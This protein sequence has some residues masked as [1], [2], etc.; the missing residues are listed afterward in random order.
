M[1]YFSGQ[2]ADNL[3]AKT[4]G[5]EAQHLQHMP[6]HSYLRIGRYHDAVVSNMVAHASD[7]H[8]EEHGAVAYAVAHDL[9]VLL[10]AAALSGEKSVAMEYS[11]IL[12]E[13]YRNHPTRRDGPGTEIGW[14]V[15]RTIRLGFGE[16][17][18]VLE[19]SDW[20]PGGDSNTAI[21]HKNA[22]DSLEYRDN[23]AL[24]P[25][26]V[27]LGHY[28]KGVASLWNIDP[29]SST[30]NRLSKANYY[31]EKLG[32]ASRFVDSDL[33]GMV[34]VA[35]WSLDASIQFYQIKSNTT[36]D[37]NDLY[38]YKKDSLEPVLELFQLART[39]QD[40]WTYT[41]PP[42]WHSD[43]KLCEGTL[44][45]IMGRYNEA[46]LAFEA[47]IIDWPKNRLALY[48]FWK[49]LKKKGAS[50]E[51]IREIENQFEKS[52]TWAD[53]NV[54]EKPPLVCPELGE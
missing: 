30:E 45:R 17:A 40:S 21:L 52:S 23:D 31:L 12:R 18:Q 32:E 33:Q 14:H 42:L 22:F 13:N 7:Q 9:V 38:H 15:W 10:C 3:L 43:I 54:K 5:K 39:E 1:A 34:Y 35:N 53:K 41:E 2:V 28:A 20:I 47:E 16:F 26:A 37:E 50:T 51:K 25:Y 6:S 4:T 49:V 36:K 44:L 29:S 24:R 46:L 27:V 11:D 8:Y 19:D 48:G